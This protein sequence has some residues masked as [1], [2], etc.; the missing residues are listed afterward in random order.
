ML[1][2]ALSK[3]NNI[4]CCEEAKMCNMR[5]EMRL[6]TRLGPGFRSLAGVMLLVFVVAQTA[7]FVHCNFGG[8]SFGMTAAKSSCHGPS[9][10]KTCHGEKSKDSNPT[11][12]CLTLKSHLISGGATDLVVPQALVVY[13]LPPWA[14]SEL[15]MLAE[16]AASNLKPVSDHT[17]RISTPEVY[18][19]PAHRSLAPPSI[20]S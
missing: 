7:C 4:C 13:L 2:F 5:T 1:I 11:S 14:L 20:P 9:Q 18:L 17:E 15:D 19:G 16:S 12:A 3:S 8:Q 6:S 10:G